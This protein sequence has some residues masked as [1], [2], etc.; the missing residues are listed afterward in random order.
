MKWYIIVGIIVVLVVIGIIVYYMHESS[1]MVYTTTL[2]GV[3]LYTGSDRPFVS[4]NDLDT[5]VIAHGNIIDFF[6]EDGVRKGK[7]VLDGVVFT[8][9]A[10]DQTEDRYLAID[11]LGNKYLIDE[12]NNTASII[13]HRYS[14]LYDTSD[15][16]YGVNNG[17]EYVIGKSGDTRPI[18]GDYGLFE[19]FTNL[20]KR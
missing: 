9:I 5:I 14:K 19:I 12:L 13:G 16:Y 6:D 10:Y 18:N 1:T 15:G 2:N 7:L 20:T 11:S 17:I 4:S 3:T 8:G